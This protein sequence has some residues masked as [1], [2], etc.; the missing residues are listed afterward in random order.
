[1][2]VVLGEPGSTLALSLTAYVTWSVV[3]SLFACFLLSTSEEE[4]V[5]VFVPL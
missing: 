3:V 2:G 1:M 5:D 4:K